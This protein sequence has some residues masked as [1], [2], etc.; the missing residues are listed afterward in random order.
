MTQKYLNNGKDTST[1]EI[2]WRDSKATRKLCY[3]K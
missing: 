3:Q 2:A 1:R